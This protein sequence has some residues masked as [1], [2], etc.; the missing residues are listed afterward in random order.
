MPVVAAVG[1]YWDLRDEFTGM[2]LLGQVVVLLV[3][4]LIG[5]CFWMPIG[6]V[7]RR[8]SRD[9]TRCLIEELS[10]VEV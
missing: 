5:L 10:L 7:H 4:L 8:Q 6:L 9:L 2:T 1:F 3:G